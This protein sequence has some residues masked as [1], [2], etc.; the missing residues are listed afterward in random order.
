MP[1]IEVEY[2]HSLETA[3]DD[4]VRSWLLSIGILSEEI[5]HHVEV[6]GESI[7]DI[8]QEQIEQG[9]LFDFNY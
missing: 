9:H 5:D 2:E 1:R 7:K 4:Q 3:T 6:L 8:A